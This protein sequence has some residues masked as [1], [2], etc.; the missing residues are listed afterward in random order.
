MTEPQR[1]QKEDQ[2]RLHSASRSLECLSNIQR[3]GV[4]LPIALLHV[5]DVVDMDS[6]I[7]LPFLAS[8]TAS[9]HTL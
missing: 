3:T 6:T 4:V 1:L 7:V 8:S 5:L 9:M 2:M